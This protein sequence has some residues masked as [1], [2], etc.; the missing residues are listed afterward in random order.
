MRIE[1]FRLAFAAF[2]IATFALPAAGN[3]ESSGQTFE[4]AQRQ[5]DPGHF[6]KRAPPDTNARK[7]NCYLVMQTV[8]LAPPPKHKGPWAKTEKKLVWKCS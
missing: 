6:P 7:Q 5:R 8:P 2:A 1:P 4:L 3:A